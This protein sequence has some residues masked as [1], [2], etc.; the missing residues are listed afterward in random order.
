MTCLSP[1]FALIFLLFNSIAVWSR[2]KFHLEVVDGEWVRW[3]WGLTS[4]FAGVFGVFFAKNSEVRSGVS[5]GNLNG[6]MGVL[7][8]S[9]RL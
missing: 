7:V 1:V 9:F 2:E 6:F 4:D 3:F 5:R 8:V